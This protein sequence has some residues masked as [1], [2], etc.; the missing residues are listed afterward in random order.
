MIPPQ[1]QELIAE[2]ELS[3]LD[4]IEQIAVEHLVTEVLIVGDPIIR[5]GGT[6]NIIL[7]LHQIDRVAR[8][9]ALDERLTQCLRG[10]GV[11][12]AQVRVVDDADLG[13]AALEVERG[14][15]T[16][17]ERHIHFPAAAFVIGVAVE[18]DPDLPV[19]LGNGRITDRLVENRDRHKLALELHPFLMRNQLGLGIVLNVHVVHRQVRRAARDDLLKNACAQR[20]KVQRTGIGV[21]HLHLDAAAQRD[22]RIGLLRLRERHRSIRTP[23]AHVIVAVAV[24]FQCGVLIVRRNLI[25]AF[26][27]RGF[28]FKAAD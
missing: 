11:V 9:G 1:K 26:A 24:V 19:A 14:C 10:R 6:V 17:E 2:A 18:G 8:V 4:P 20:V 13:H 23:N 15:I 27:Y 28:A 16:V 22:G 3:G 12:D 7:H 5:N 21:R 25:P